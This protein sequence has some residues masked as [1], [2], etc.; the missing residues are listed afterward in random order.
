MTRSAISPRL[1]ISTLRNIHDPAES[2][3]LAA[4]A[5]LVSQACRALLTPLA[6]LTPI[7]LTPAGWKRGAAQ[8]RWAGRWKQRH[9]TISP[10]AS[11]SISFIS[12]MASTMQITCPFP[13]DRRERQRRRRRAKA[14]RKGADNGRLD[15]VQAGLG[16]AA[17]AASAALAG[18]GAPTRLWPLH[19]GAEPAARQFRQS[20]R[21]RAWLNLSRIFR[22][23]RS[24]SNSAT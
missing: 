21:S 18:C 9:L 1:A 16:S 14:S 17:T 12:F 7:F 22:S 13:R 5:G 11:D 23:P 4:L 24:R 10:A 20:G 3:L 2:E 6:R 19:A 15:H 8:T